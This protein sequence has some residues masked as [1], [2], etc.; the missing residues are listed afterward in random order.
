MYP[1]R[2]RIHFPPNEKFGKS[3]IIHASSTQKC[4]L[5]GGNQRDGSQKC[6]LSS[7]QKLLKTPQDTADRVA[8][9]E[10]DGKTT[11]SD[12]VLQ[13]GRFRDPSDSFLSFRGGR[14]HM[15]IPWK[16]PLQ[17]AAQKFPTLFSWIIQKLS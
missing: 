15:F 14:D 11:I 6:Y 7:Y 16:S 9:S 5:G 2:G 8:K 17:T 1:S 13:T 4:R 3:C 12:P 10:N